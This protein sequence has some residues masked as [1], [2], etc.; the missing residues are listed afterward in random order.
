MTIFTEHDGVNPVVAEVIRSGF[1]ESRHRG[2]L[3]GLRADGSTALAA[4]AV[5][6]PFFPRSSNKPLQAAGCCVAA[7]T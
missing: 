1:L 6:E 5:D 7:W 3:V 2:V 4:G